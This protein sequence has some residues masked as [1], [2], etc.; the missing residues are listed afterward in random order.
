M[1]VGVSRLSLSYGPAVESG[2]YFVH[3]LYTLDYSRHGDINFECDHVA[4]TGVYRRCVIVM[5]RSE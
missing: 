1:T 2:K 4:V 3:T 5:G